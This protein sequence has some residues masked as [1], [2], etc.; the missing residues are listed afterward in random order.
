LLAHFD[1]HLVEVLDHQ[2]PAKIHSLLVEAGGKFTRIL[3]LGC[4]TGLAAPYLATFGG[5]MTGSI[6]RRACWTKRGS[7]IS[8]TV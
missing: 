5:K 6:F 1:K 8:M 2:V 7:V 4:G 3:D